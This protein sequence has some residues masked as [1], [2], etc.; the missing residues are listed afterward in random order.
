MSTSLSAQNHIE[1]DTGTVAKKVLYFLH[2]NLVSGTIYLTGAG[3]QSAVAVQP[4]GIPYYGMKTLL[5]KV[6][7][8]TKIAFE[9]CIYLTE[10]KEKK[11]IN[12]LF[13]VD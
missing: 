7:P 3:F 4:Q 12:R 8:G 2:R 5:N 10:E 9:N 13:V 11:I 1:P 6:V